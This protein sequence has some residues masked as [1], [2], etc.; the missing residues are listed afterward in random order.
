MTIVAGCGI[1]T[2]AAMKADMTESIPSMGKGANVRY[3]EKHYGEG[4]GSGARVLN[5]VT[6]IYLEWKTLL[7][8]TPS[9]LRAVDSTVRETEVEMG[10]DSK[11]L[12]D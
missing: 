11:L 1:H 6:K 12:R 4:E 5:P 8:W 9:R 3:E 7:R 10:A 2:V